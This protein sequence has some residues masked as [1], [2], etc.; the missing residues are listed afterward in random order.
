VYKIEFVKSAEKALLSLPNDHMA[1][2]YQAIEKLIQNPFPHGYKKLQG[3]KNRYRIRVGIYRVLYI[4]E[5]NELVIVVIKIG[6]RKDVY[7]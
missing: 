3:Y 4:I 7:E 5:N 6:H 2:I 1:R